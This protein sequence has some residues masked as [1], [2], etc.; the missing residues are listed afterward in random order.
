M[1]KCLSVVCMCTCMYVCVWGGG[2]E[3]EREK[4]SGYPM[5]RGWRVGGK[6]NKREDIN[7]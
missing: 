5:R 4:G 6:G 2:R 3:E 7:M 1:V